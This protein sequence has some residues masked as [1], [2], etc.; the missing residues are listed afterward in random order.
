MKKNQ[1]VIPYILLLKMVSFRENMI[2]DFI[3]ST[4]WIW[5]VDPINLEVSQKE[6]VYIIATKV[7]YS[8]S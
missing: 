8:A 4:V 2:S 6:N 3:E 7:I 5:D 1:T